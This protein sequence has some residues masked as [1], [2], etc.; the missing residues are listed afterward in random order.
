MK[1][2]D[3][4]R[5]RTCEIKQTVKF[6]GPQATALKAIHLQKFVTHTPFADISP[7]LIQVIQSTKTI[8]NIC[9][10]GYIYF[11]MQLLPSAQL[12]W[13]GWGVSN[14][15]FC[16]K[17]PLSSVSINYCRRMKETLPRHSIFDPLT[18]RQ[19]KVKITFVFHEG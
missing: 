9:I 3:K 5:K 2:A 17:T 1:S 13:G 16:E 18:I 11:C 8:R 15:I 4:K 14:S 19:E 7:H 12:R 6:A 10:S